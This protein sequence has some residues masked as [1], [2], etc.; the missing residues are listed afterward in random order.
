M[1]NILLKRNELREG[2]VRMSSMRFD[3]ELKQEEVDKVAMQQKQLYKKWKFYD[4][5]IKATS[6]KKEV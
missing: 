3:P 5:F 6:K 1:K 2:S 4:G